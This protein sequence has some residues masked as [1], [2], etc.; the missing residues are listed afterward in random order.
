MN[1]SKDMWSLRCS[2]ARRCPLCGGEAGF[3]RDSD[4]YVPYCTNC[5][6][7][8]SFHICGLS[9]AV[10]AW[11]DKN[12]KLGHDF[13]DEATLWQKDFA[14]RIW[15]LLGEPL[16]NIPSKE[17]FKE[18]ISEHIAKFK[19]ATTRNNCAIRQRATLRLQ[20]AFH[21]DDFHECCGDE[22]AAFFGSTDEI[23]C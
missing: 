17:N 4:G 13:I 2:E 5:L 8:L 18:Y 23:F 11:N 3:P 10:K 21:G 14:R 9:D 7:H 12:A 16:P 1:F 20:G 19:E 22:P 15:A 6:S